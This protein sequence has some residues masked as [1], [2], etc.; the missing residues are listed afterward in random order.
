MQLLHHISGIQ[1][2]VSGR[3]LLLLS[4]SLWFDLCATERNLAGGGVGGAVGGTVSGGGER[5]ASSALRSHAA[6]A[7]VER[8]QEIS[9]RQVAKTRP[10]FILQVECESE[11]ARGR[12]SD[13][14]VRSVGEVE[15][16]E[17][18]GGRVGWGDGARQPQI[19]KGEKN[20]CHCGRVEAL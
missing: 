10:L 16:K 2:L 19:I 6:D 11:V 5:A 12:A 1:L 17:G 3:S 4:L 13:G 7:L 18:V 8:A 14:G 15:E 20:P 9:D